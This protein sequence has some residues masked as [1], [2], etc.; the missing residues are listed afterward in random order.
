MLDKPYNYSFA[1]QSLDNKYKNVISIIDECF[2]LYLDE[3]EHL[4]TPYMS[5]AIIERVRQ[6]F[7]KVV[8]MYY[9]KG[10]MNEVW[11]SLN[12]LVHSGNNIVEEFIS[13]CKSVSPSV[14]WKYQ[15]SKFGNLLKVKAEVEKLIDFLNDVILI[16]KLMELNGVLNNR[17][18]AIKK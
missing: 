11:I 17:A 12:S 13:Q 16:R 2:S 5:N 18:N 1:Y 9:I 7:P 14:D 8:S 4:V 3:M 6:V 10:L 15:K